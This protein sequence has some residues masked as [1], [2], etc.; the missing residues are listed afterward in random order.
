VVIRG[1]AEEAKAESLICALS[2]DVDDFVPCEQTHFWP[3]KTSSSL[4]RWKRVQGSVPSFPLSKHLQGSVHSFLSRVRH[5]EAYAQ[6]CVYMRERER[7]CVFLLFLNH[8]RIVFY[9]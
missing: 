8:W 3:T 4:P 6:V 9:N 1:E 7:V 5:W 2:Y